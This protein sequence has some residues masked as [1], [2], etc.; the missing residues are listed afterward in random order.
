QR[1]TALNHVLNAVPKD[2][3]HLLVHSQ[4]GVG[5]KPPMARDYQCAPLLTVPVVC[6]NGHQLQAI[7]PLDHSLNAPPALHVD[8]R[9]LGWVENVTGANHIGAAKKHHAGPVGGRRLMTY[10]NTFTIKIEV[11][12]GF[13]V[14]VVWPRIFGHRSSLAGR[15]AHP[16]QNRV[17]RN[18]I[19]ARCPGSVAEELPSSGTVEYRSTSLPHVLVTAYMVFSIVGIDDVGEGPFT[20]RPDCVEHLIA[21]G[22]YAGVHQ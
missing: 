13:C 14:R 4:I 5:T 22:G 20:E 21:H 1:H 3:D 18:D 2:G 7:Q 15:R 8:D 16:L 11:L 17:E 10:R 12:L 19:G 6:R 9:V